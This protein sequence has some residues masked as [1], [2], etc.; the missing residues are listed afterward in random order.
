MHRNPIECASIGTQIREFARI[1]LVIS[2][3]LQGALI[4]AL[5]GRMLAHYPVFECLIFEPIQP[6]IRL[7]QYLSIP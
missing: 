6:N 3:Q 1:G 7:N 5:A 2:Q 4:A